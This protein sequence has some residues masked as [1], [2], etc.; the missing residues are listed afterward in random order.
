MNS[1]HSFHPSTF[2]VRIS[3]ITR[4]ID[5]LYFVVAVIE[6]LLH[7]RLLRRT[8][9]HFSTTLLHLTELV[10]DLLAFHADSTMTPLDLDLEF[11]RSFACLLAIAFQLTQ[12]FAEPSDELVTGLLPLIGRVAPCVSVVR[13]SRQH[14]LDHVRATVAGI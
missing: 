3:H 10:I 13:V 4:A 5:S 1:F 8:L 6:R 7:L 2:T 14:V 11:F 9:K 12:H